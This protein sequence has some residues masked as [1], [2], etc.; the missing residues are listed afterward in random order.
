[1]RTLFLHIGFHKTGSSALQLAL[2]QSTKL[3][4]SRGIEFLSLG[5]KGSSSRTIDIQKKNGRMSYRLNWRIGDLLAISRGDNVVISAEHLCFLHTFEDIDNLYRICRRFFDRC[6]II[7]YLRR[8][9]LQAFSFK[10]QAARAAAPNI[11]PSS[12]LFGHCDGAFPRL[13]DDLMVYFDYFSKLKIWA[14]VFGDTALNV[15]EFSME[16]LHKGDVISDFCSLLGK[17]VDIPSV[18]VNEGVGRKEFLLTNKLIELGIAESEIKKLKSMMRLE[19]SEFSPSKI[20][21]ERFY[22]LFEYCNKPLNDHFLQH[23]SGLAFNND[24]SNYPKEGNDCLTLQDLSGWLPQILASGIRHPQQV[25]DSL[26]R[27]RLQSL[28]ISNTENPRLLR[29]LEGAV[30]CLSPAVNIKQVDTSWF[31]LVRG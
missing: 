11:S 27:E 28:L 16:S 10:R 3:L 8:Q 6:R 18:R 13:N 14:S 9:D 5:K 29:E 12:Q 2:K 1:M 20:E 30:K 15:R 31:G 25:R 26:L 4:S 17:G 24:L 23:S 19:V 22:R 21:A 7:V